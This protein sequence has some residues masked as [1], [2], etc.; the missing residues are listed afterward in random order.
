ML[1]IINSIFFCLM[2]I[3]HSNIMLYSIQMELGNGSTFKL[4]TVAI[5]QI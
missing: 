4:V 3:R 2:L 1:N 5:A